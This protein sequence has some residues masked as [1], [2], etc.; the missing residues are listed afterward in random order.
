MFIALMR[1]IRIVIITCTHSPWEGAES[2][3]PRFSKALLQ[4]FNLWKIPDRWKVLGN[5]NTL[6]C[7]KKRRVD[8]SLLRI[9]R[10]VG[11][12][13]SNDEADLV[14]VVFR[15]DT[16]YPIFCP[17]NILMQATS[18]QSLT[19]LIPHHEMVP[20]NLLL[21]KRKHL[22]LFVCI[23]WWFCELDGANILFLFVFVVVVVCFSSVTDFFAFPLSQAAG[24][25]LAV[26][27]M[28]IW[29]T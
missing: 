15:W 13:E 19:P 2:E 7:E 1:F 14:R 16:K 20:V 5:V 18:K 17:K 10:R 9:G 25:L 8:E 28:L 23:R 22:C 24:F 12:W 6:K 4:R 26:S 27:C 11:F 3:S 29:Y 21:R